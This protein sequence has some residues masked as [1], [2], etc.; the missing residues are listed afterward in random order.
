MSTAIDFESPIVESLRIDIGIVVMP[1]FSVKLF[2]PGLSTKL[3]D[4]G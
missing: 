2:I 4:S 1:C 3:A